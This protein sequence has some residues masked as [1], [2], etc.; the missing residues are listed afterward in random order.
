MLSILFD[1]GVPRP[2]GMHL[3]GQNRGGGAGMR[4]GN[5]LFSCMADRS[6]SESFLTR[7]VRG[8]LVPQGVGRNVLRGVLL[9]VMLGAAAGMVGCASP[10]IEPVV[11]VPAGRYEEAFQSAREVLRERRF[12]IDRVDARAGVITTRARSSA[13]LVTPWDGDQSTIEQEIDDAAN[14]QQRRVRIEFVPAGVQSG[15][16]SAGA[17]GGGSEPVVASPEDALLTRDL[18]D[19]AFAGAPMVANVRVIVERINRPGRQLSTKTTRVTGFSPELTRPEGGLR[20]LEDDDE[21][22]RRLAAEISAKLGVA[23]TAAVEKPA[24]TLTPADQPVSGAPAAVAPSA[25]EPKP[26]IWD[27]PA[28][29]VA[30][31]VVPAQSTPVQPSPVTMPKEPE[32]PPLPPR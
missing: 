30:Q 23:T 5:P 22:A 3:R 6:P 28:E 4:T 29:P 7:R 19:A 26:S 18:R 8:G 2:C 16:A 25:P 13:G 9:G 15:A 20:R 14:W 24:G 32:L 11:D 27:V 17:A 1:P 12:S 10:R 21:F 31:P